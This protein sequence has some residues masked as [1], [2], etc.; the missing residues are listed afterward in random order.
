MAKRKR[1]A[2]EE[3]SKKTNTEFLW[4]DDEIQ[5]QL[6]TSFNFNSKCEFEGRS[7][8]SVKSKYEQMF[9]NMSKAYPEDPERFP[10]K[11]TITKNASQQN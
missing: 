10:N 9:E 1:K 8:E 5:L 3:N 6:Q 7:W 2:S 11:S 4:T